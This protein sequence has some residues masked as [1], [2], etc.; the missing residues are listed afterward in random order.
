V[1][2]LWGRNGELAEGDR[3]GWF[4]VSDYEQLFGSESKQGAFIKKAIYHCATPRGPRNSQVRY[5]QRSCL[6]SSSFL[7]DN[8][9]LNTDARARISPLDSP[10]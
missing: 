7:L 10:T 4:D 1:R 3:G 8:H 2:N 5:H 9:Y 6:F